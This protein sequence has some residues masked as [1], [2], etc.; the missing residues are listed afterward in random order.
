MVETRWVTIRT[1]LSAIFF[2]LTFLVGVYGMNFDHMPELHWRY[3][4]HGVLTFM[5]AVIVTALLVFWRRQWFSLRPTRRQIVKLF[6]VEPRQLRGH[7]NRAPHPP[8]ERAV[9]SRES[10]HRA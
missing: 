4:Y 10:R 5:A 8:A 7:L 1:V 9:S 2:P 3:G 6:T